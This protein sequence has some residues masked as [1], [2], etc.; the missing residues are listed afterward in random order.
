MKPIIASIIL[1]LTILESCH[2]ITQY[3]EIPAIE[4][5]SHIARDS[6]DILGNSTRY[7]EL[8]FSII[9]GDGDFG[10]AD[11][12]TLPPF[13]TIYN[14][15]FFPT[16]FTKNDTGFVEVNIAYPNFRI[17]FVQ[18]ENHKAYKADIIIEMEYI[19]AFLQ[20][21]TIKYDFFVVDKA[22]NES[23]TITTPEII[24]EY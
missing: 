22:L 3:S 23:N 16:L 19:S 1:S 9:D 13:D 7:I 15:N 2:E 8:S 6:V 17:P 24:F 18:V 12:D 5:K 21:D 4:Y 14:F 11:E 10:L 20:S